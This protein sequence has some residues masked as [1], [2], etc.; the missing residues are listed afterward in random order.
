M[1]DKFIIIDLLLMLSVPTRRNA[2][3]LNCSEMPNF[4]WSDKNCVCDHLCYGLASFGLV[5]GNCFHWTSW[6]NA[7][8][9]RKIVQMVAIAVNLLRETPTVSWNFQKIGEHL[10]FI[11]V[12]KFEYKL[13]FGKFST[14]PYFLRWHH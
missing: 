10:K 14:N 5:L 7:A 9:N 6:L 4:Y 8:D 3:L 1:T 12:S 2:S 13:D 11:F